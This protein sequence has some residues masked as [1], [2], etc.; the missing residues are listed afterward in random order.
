[1]RYFVLLLLSFV[2]MGAECEAERLANLDDNTV[3]NPPVQVPWAIQAHPDAEIPEGGLQAA[4]DQWNDWASMDGV[5]RE[6]Y[7]V[8]EVDWLCDYEQIGT[9]IVETNYLPGGGGIDDDEDP[10]ELGHF[11]GILDREGNTLYGVITL[12]ADWPYDEAVLLHEMGE[13]M[14]LRDDPPS[15]DLNSIMSDPNYGQGSLTPGD[16][17][18]LVEA[19]GGRYD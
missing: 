5:T 2:L 11:H 8:C 18:A 15:I 10:E 4:V 6:W 9:L 19:L 1:M 16:H 7:V 3:Y 14:G 17:T 13:A 12:S